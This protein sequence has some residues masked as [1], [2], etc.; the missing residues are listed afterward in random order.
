[1]RIKN[2]KTG[3]VLYAKNNLAEEEFRLFEVKGSRYHYIYRNITLE[4]LI[5]DWVVYEKEYYWYINEEFEVIK[6]PIT[7][8][9]AIRHK[10]VGNYFTSEIEAIKRLEGI[11]CQEQKRVH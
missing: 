5:E 3:E 2:I 4:E 7:Y 11:K 6:A 10:E 1:M 9:K 8:F